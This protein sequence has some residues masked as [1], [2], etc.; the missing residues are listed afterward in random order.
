[1]PEFP[2]VVLTI[3]KSSCSACSQFITGTATFA[4]LFP[5]S[6]ELMVEEISTAVFPFA[7]VA[8]DTGACFNVT[9][10]PSVS[11]LALTV[12][13]PLFSV[14]FPTTNKMS[15]NVEPGF[16]VMFTIAEVVEAFRLSNAF[17]VS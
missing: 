3:F 17:A 13:S 9:E 5:T 8:T 4:N 11:S 10:Y 16:T 12:L 7:S 6:V 2:P 1:M 15:P 14:R